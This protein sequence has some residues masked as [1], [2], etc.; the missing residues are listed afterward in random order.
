M[1]WFGSLTNLST[2]RTAEKPDVKAV[3]EHDG[4]LC[5]ATP[6][7]AAPGDQSMDDME[8]CL[9]SPGYARSTEM[10][11]H[12]GTVPRSQKQKKSCKGKKKK[13]MKEEEDD[14]GPDGGRSLRKAGEHVRDSPLLSALSSLSLNSLDQNLP[15]P[16]TARPLPAT[17]TLSRASPLTLVPQSCFNDPMKSPEAKTKDAVG[18]F[19]GPSNMAASSPKAV[20]SQDL[21]VPMDPI[22]EKQLTATWTD[23]RTDSAASRVNRKPHRILQEVTDGGGEYVKFS[24]DKF[25]LEPPSDKLRKQLEEELKLS[26]SN[27]KSHAWYHGGIPWEV[28]ESLVV[29]HGDFLIR[30]SRS[31]Q[32]DFVLTSH[33]EQKT[34]HFPVRRTVVQSGETYT[35]V[36]YSLEG[37]AFD[38]LPALVHFYVGSR[39]VLTRWS[40]AEIHRPVNR[41]LPLSYLETAF[42]T[43]VSSEEEV[44]PRSDM[45]DDIW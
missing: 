43:A 2:R 45:A 4:S 37:E 21:Y 19:R 39:A 33:W 29:N 12:V 24:R 25:W 3:P 20:L 13:K 42:G 8:S 41:T 22:T 31:S 17:P 16:A 35:R 26:G 10:Y 40:R 38:S 36:K 30:D 11:T 18:P 44:C 15:L 32:G 14:E 28:S 9:H 5:D 1:K 27:L 34:L 6:V 7:V 23:R